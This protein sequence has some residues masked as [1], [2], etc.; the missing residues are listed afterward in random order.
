MLP[1]APYRTASSVL[2]G[3]GLS[4]PSG[5]CLL[6]GIH[7]QTDGTAAGPSHGRGNADG[8]GAGQ[9]WL[10]GGVTVFVTSLRK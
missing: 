3:T 10:P 5:I 1:S 7:P 9:G 2:L 8:L 6:G 4:L